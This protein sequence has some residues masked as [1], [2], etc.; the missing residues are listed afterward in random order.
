MRKIINYPDMKAIWLSQFD[1]ADVYCVRGVQR[2]EAEYTRLA[3]SIIGRIKSLGF[4][5][6]II[7]IRPYGDSFYPSVYYPASRFVTGSYANGFSYDP[8]GIFVSLAHSAELSVQA[9]INPLRLMREDE[10]GGIDVSNVLKK[11][12][13]EGKLKTFEERLYLDPAYEDARALVADGAR[14]ALEKYDFDGLHIDDY[15]YPTT[16]ASF[17]GDTFGKSGEAS[18]EKFRVDNID[19]LVKGLYDAVKSVD[20]R[21]IFGAAPSGNLGTL[22]QKYYADAEKWCSSDGYIDYIM[23]Q[24]YFGLEHSVCPF[25]ETCEK[26][27]SIIKN[28]N[29]RLYIGMTLGKAVNGAK[30]IED[31]YGGSGKREWIENHDVL[32]RCFEYLASS[33]VADGISIF[34]YQYFY[35][36]VSGKPNE[37][38]ASE[39]AAFLPYLEDKE[40]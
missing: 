12:Y 19:S 27:R 30:G 26:W 10:I 25:A 22:K 2:D 37:Y 9:W 36:P 28:E 35:D 15:F 5:T 13:V 29:V 1:M 16:D 24:I 38:S 39:R 8:V 34:C 11:W 23:P 14:E 40:A 20:E 7:Q 33:S 17:D 32:C 21:L 4:N 31:M 6:V 18:L 3:E